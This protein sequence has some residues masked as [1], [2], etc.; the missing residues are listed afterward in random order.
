ML[1]KKL[2]PVKYKSKALLYF[3]P[4]SIFIRNG[5]VNVSVVKKKFDA[6]R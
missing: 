5:D 4:V 2:I 1:I 6:K 3:S